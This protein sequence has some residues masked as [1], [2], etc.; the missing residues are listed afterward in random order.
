MILSSF[1]NN[2]P[3][4]IVFIE[5]IANRNVYMSGFD[6]IFHSSFCN[7]GGSLT[8][9]FNK[10]MLLFRCEKKFVMYNSYV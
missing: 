3:S 2:N 4:S 7:V 1:L 9:K 10:I 5:R 6:Q 8:N